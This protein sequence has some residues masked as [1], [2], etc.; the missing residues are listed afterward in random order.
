MGVALLCLPSS[1]PAPGPA[2]VPSHL[3]RSTWD[4]RKGGL[5]GVS[6]GCGLPVAR[7]RVAE[8]AS[9]PLV[10]WAL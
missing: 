3:P 6:G 2:S 10:A 5:A 1:M 8:S 4:T 7:K 9:G